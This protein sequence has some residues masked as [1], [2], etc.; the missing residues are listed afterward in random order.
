MVAFRDAF[1]TFQRDAITCISRV[2][3]CLYR[4][5]QIKNLPI[6]RITIIR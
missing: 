3:M 2:T 4:N 6:S 1:A 5:Q